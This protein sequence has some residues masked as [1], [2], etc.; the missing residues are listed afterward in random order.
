M[1]NTQYLALKRYHNGYY[2]IYRD[3]GSVRLSF[4]ASSYL[5]RCAIRSVSWR[6]TPARPHS[7]RPPPPP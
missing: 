6:S 4:V 1:I 7:L 2:L 5:S 3:L